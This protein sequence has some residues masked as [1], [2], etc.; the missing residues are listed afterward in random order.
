MHINH[1]PCDCKFNAW[2]HF[3]II[4]CLVYA[5]FCK[6]TC[7]ICSIFVD[8]YNAFPRSIFASTFNGT[9]CKYFIVFL[10]YSRLISLV[11]SLFLTNTHSYSNCLRFVYTNWK[12]LGNTNKIKY[13]PTVKLLSFCVYVC[14][15][16]FLRLCVNIIKSENA[17]WNAHHWKYWIHLEE[18]ESYIYALF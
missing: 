3:N 9:A 1:F 8:I 5:K 11:F 7:Y 14:G 2:S 10:A 6:C 12:S 13:A 15:Y 18:S 4:S 17:K 16:W